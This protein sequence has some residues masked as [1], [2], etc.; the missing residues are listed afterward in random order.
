MERRITW[1]ERIFVAL[2]FTLFCIIIVFIGKELV[3]TVTDLWYGLG[4]AM[5][6][7]GSLIERLPR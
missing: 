4:N 7:F 6:E 2:S 5:M 1:S 3:E